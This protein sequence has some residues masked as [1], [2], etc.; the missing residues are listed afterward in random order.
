MEEFENWYR[1]AFIGD[2]DEES[3]ANVRCAYFLSQMKVV[4][5][6]IIGSKSRRKGR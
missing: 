6:I 5:H 2:S 3:R 1:A 4:L